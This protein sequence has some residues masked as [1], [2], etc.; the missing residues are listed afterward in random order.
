MHINVK[1]IYFNY[2]IIFL[3][4]IIVFDNTALKRSTLQAAV[5][6]AG[7]HAKPYFVNEACKISL[8]VLTIDDTVIS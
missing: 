4:H 2:C 5:P 3:I 7:M 8:H 1:H 6:S